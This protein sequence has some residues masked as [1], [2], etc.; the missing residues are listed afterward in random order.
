MCVKTP[1]PV[2]RHRFRPMN[3][4]LFDFDARP[5]FWIETEKDS[6]RNRA[7]GGENVSLRE[8]R[9]THILS[10]YARKAMD[11]K[12]V[13]KALNFEAHG[14]CESKSALSVSYNKLFS[15]HWTIQNL[16]YRKADLRHELVEGTHDLVRASIFKRLVKIRTR[17]GHHAHSGINRR[18]LFRVKGQR[19]TLPL[20]HPR[21]VLRIRRNVNRLRLVAVSKNV[22]WRC[23]ASTLIQKSE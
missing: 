1:T 4:G 22:I 17:E 19:N 21:P 8:S 14:L 23:R 16:P 6:G 10:K 11:P 15:V 13:I 3:S 2:E 18:L 7:G 5:S 9:R 12:V 20:L